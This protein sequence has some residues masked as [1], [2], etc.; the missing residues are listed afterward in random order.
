MAV[1]LLFSSMLGGRF[2]VVEL[3]IFAY[4]SGGDCIVVGSNTVESSS[5]VELHSS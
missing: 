4:D 3:N 1:L 5:Y 2:D